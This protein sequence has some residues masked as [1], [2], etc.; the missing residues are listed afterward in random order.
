M[1]RAGMGLV[2][3]KFLDVLYTAAKG[4]PDKLPW[5]RQ[6][7]DR[8]LVSL[9]ETTRARGRVLDIGCGSGVF[10]GYLAGQGFQVTAIDLHPDAVAM[11]RARSAASKTPFTVLPGDV[12]ALR[13]DEPFDV[14]FDSGCLHNM[15][16][17]GMRAYRARLIESW[18]RPGG[19]FLLEH[20]VKR[21]PLDW[22]PV[23]P[24]RRS[25]LAEF[26]A[27]EF[28]PVETYTEE[29]RLPLP[30]GPRVAAAAYRLRRTR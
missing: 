29:G 30:L 18:L 16:R 21:H 13:P 6:E 8:L 12:L 20:W 23:G 26:F 10:A 27:P 25:G 24:R 14:V 5:S 19:E 28:E 22:R 9:V 11:A 1:T 4:Q 3:R 2:Q 17:A 15:N 7:P